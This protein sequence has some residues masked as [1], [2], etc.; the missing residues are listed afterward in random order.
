MASPREEIRTGAAYLDAATEL[1]RRVRTAHPTA[2]LM[3]AADLQW[4]WRTPRPTDDLGQVFWFDDA[5]RPDAA[6]IATDWGDGIAL[7]P[8]LLPDATPD[9]VAHVVERGFARAG[10]SGL[11]VVEV[12]VDRADDVM[13]TILA[14]HD[15]E[16]WMNADARP[17]VSPLAG[18]YR[19]A[20]RLDT[21]PRPHHLIGRNGPDVETRLRQTSLYRA[22]LDLVVLDR[23]DDV[24][25]YGV[26]WFDPQTR[27]GLV[28]PM[29]TED[30]HQRRGLA[31][32]V[33]TAGLDRLAGAGAERVKICF[34]PD[35]PASGHLY[36]DVGFA[37][38][39]STVV[40]TGRVGA[41]T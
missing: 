24:A 2:G 1:L 28:E 17:D 37:P 35:N 19:L 25:A 39:R 16:T 10:A 13:L 8:I 33:L 34:R 7:D 30:T 32:H 31:R 21:A 26:F 41:P 38:V 36:L 11:D 40:L 14:G 6:M 18:G 22:D 4:W 9:R 29:R 12:M 27:T 3:E 23:R 20:S 5:G 15:V